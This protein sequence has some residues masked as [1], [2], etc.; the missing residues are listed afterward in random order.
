M[1]DPGDGEA[2]VFKDGVFDD[3]AVPQDSGLLF[4]NRGGPVYRF[5]P[6]P[7]PDNGRRTLAIIAVSAALA[8]IVS[9]VAVGALFNASGCLLYTSPSPRDAT[10]SRMPSSA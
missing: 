9:A 5:E 7:E 4:G 8:I 1:V 2:S 10:L 3:D 6:E